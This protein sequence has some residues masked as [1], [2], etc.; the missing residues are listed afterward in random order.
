M[1]PIDRH[2]RGVRAIAVTPP[3]D[4]GAPVGIAKFP[5]DKRAAGVMVAPI[6]SPTTGDTVAARHAC[7]CAAPGPDVPVAA[8]GGRLAA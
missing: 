7:V 6:A 4:T 3:T 1:T 2:T 8:S 5:T